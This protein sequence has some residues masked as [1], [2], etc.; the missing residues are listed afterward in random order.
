M[1]GSFSSTPVAG[2]LLW[3]VAWGDS[4][5]IESIY[6]TP[7]GYVKLWEDQPT[8]GAAQNHIAAYCRFADG[9]DPA[10]VWT[11]LLT[12]NNHDWVMEEWYGLASVDNVGSKNKNSASGDLATSGTATDPN[13]SFLLAAAISRALTQTWVSPTTQEYS[14]HYGSAVT[15]CA[16]SIGVQQLAAAAASWTVTANFPNAS[17]PHCVGATP[18][19]R[20]LV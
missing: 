14:P 15:N 10:P 7:S 1:T 5:T 12:N 4:N 6:P 16:V 2:H 20:L 19:K 13:G 18:F 9:S 17:S 11:G 3:L 8:F